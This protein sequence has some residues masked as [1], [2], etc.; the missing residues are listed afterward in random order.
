MLLTP[1]RVRP[2]YQND[3]AHDFDHVLRVW[4]TAQFIGRTEQAN[5]EILNA[6]VL[7]HD[8]ARADQTRTG[9]DHALEG[10]RR[11]K[12]FLQDDGCPPEFVL[13]VCH[14]IETHRFRTGCAPQ[15]LEAKILYDAD[16]LDSIGAIGVA[17]AFAFG[18]HFNQPLWRDTDD[19]EH[20]ALQEFRQKL[21]KVKDKLFTATAKKI[22]EQRHRVMV[23]FFEQLAAEIKGER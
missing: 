12:K 3:V 13:A 23:E 10:A 20:T 19:G 17:R 9:V 8:I 6:A 7:L 18:G 14:A 21:A 11:A 5:L 4:A 15:T 22:A 2:L 1:E 16:K